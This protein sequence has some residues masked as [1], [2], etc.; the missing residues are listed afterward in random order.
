M[1]IPGSNSKPAEMTSQEMTDTSPHVH[2]DATQQQPDSTM[3]L[4]PIVDMGTDLVYSSSDEPIWA[5][6]SA[7][8]DRIN[9]RASVT[10]DSDISI[11]YGQIQRERIDLTSRLFEID[12]TVSLIAQNDT[13]QAKRLNSLKDHIQE[14]ETKWRAMENRYERLN[15]LEMR[16]NRVRRPH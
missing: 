13:G 8:I 10:L 14:I 15:R 12:Q 16:R 4:D 1:S 11:V 9:A 7:T 3:D 5:K 6:V 2:D